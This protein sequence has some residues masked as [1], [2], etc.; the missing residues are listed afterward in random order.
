LRQE[1][2]GSDGSGIGLLEERV[3]K[4]KAGKEEREEGE[5][6]RNVN[7]ETRVA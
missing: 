6:N 1:K 7:E 2:E 3:D 5:S 4:T